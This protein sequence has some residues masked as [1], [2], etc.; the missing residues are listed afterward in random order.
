MITASEIYWILKLDDIQNFFIFLTAFCGIFA[1]I[2]TILYL[3]NLLD[4]YFDKRV[5][6]AVKPWWI[7]C[8]LCLFMS[9]TA[10]CLTPTTKQM[11]MIKVIPMI[12]NSEAIETMSNDAKEIYTLG[13]K[14]IK[15][16]LT[17]KEQGK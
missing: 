13:I 6:Y 2:T 9:V 10:L 1:L 16:Q 7:L 14:A 11:A 15:E 12:A 3:V 5:A 17:G 8:L 4:S